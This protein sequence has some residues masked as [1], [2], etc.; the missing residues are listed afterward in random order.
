MTQIDTEASI[1]LVKW[2]V[3]QIWWNDRALD[4]GPRGPVFESRSG[5]LVSNLD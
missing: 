4:S 5:Q 3:D 2:Y 1:P